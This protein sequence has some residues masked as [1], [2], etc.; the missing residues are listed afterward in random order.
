MSKDDEIKLL[1]TVS[2][3]Q[4][5]EEALAEIDAERSGE[6]LGLYSNWKSMN[7]AMGK[8]WRFNQVT[9]IACRSKM[10]KSYVLNQLHFDFTDVADRGKYKALN[11]GINFPVEVLAFGFEMDPRDEV[12]RHISRLTGK[13]TNHLLS[14]QWD[15]EDEIFN[16]I[17]NEEYNN[18]VNQSNW[19][20]GRKITY[21]PDAGTWR[22]IYYTAKKFVAAKRANNPNTMFIITL[23]H[24][25]LARKAEERNDSELIGNIAYLL[26]LLRK[27]FKAMVIVLGQMNNNILQTDRMTVPGLQY[28]N[29]SDIYIGSQIN[30]AC[31]NVWIFPYRP[32][33]LNLETYGN[34]RID[35]KDLVIAA[36]V[37]NR[38]GTIGELYFKNNLAKGKLIELS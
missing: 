24:Y 37:K 5:R 34:D 12:H 11:T 6:Q 9:H 14:S 29:E 23:D 7:R 8:Y 35:T 33:L 38:R 17:N 36:S 22:Q 1:R 25:L 20:K 3:D 31:D 27:H 4:A 32:E 10:G 28:P 13:T 21:V 15:Y 18:I 19:L 26:I 30:W 16:T 2:I